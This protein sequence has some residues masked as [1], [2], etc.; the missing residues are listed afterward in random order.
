MGE[1]HHH[2]GVRPVR[3]HGATLPAAAGVHCEVRGGGRGV[4]GALAPRYGSESR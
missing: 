4:S 1:E 3:R 2:G